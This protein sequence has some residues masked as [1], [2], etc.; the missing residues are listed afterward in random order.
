MLGTDTAQQCRRSLSEFQNTQNDIY[1]VA[2]PGGGKTTPL[3]AHYIVDL[4]MSGSNV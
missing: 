1:V 4:L 2:P 3:M